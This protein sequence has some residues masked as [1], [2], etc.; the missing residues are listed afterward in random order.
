[1]TRR[2]RLEA[3]VARREEWADKADARRDAAH[4]GVERIA[5]A[6]PF[7]QPIL[8]GHHSERHARRDQERIR[9]GMDR[10]L[11]ESKLA[12]HHRSKASGLEAQLDRSVFSDDEN[13]VAALEARITEREAECAR[14][15]AVNAAWRKLG[16][17]SKLEKLAQLAAS[18]VVTP[19]EALEI[20]RFFALC[21]WEEN[22]YPAYANTNARSAIR[23]DRERI[24]EIQARAAR[25][26]TAEQAGGVAIEA[27][28]AAGDGESYTRVTF[29]EKP[30]REVLEALRAA[31]FSWGRGSWVGKST[32]LPPCVAELV[33]VAP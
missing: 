18:N 26:A 14:R 8:V 30:A 25:A 21:H 5:S 22:P 20:S 3:K 10:A 9:S 32:S 7:G 28:G 4:A 17:G 2:Q 16:D 6:I 13:A 1:M 29:A 23:R 31:G 33:K 19:A 12:D 15:K 11:A 27:L 24:A